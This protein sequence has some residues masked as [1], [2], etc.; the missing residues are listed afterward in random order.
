MKRLAAYGI[1]EAS[2]MPGLITNAFDLPIFSKQ[3]EI[4]KLPDNRD[5]RQMIFCN[6]E[7]DPLNSL[8][9]KIVGP[10]IQE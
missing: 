10:K 6:I 4:S 5:K 8:M 1:K 2:I 9:I 3:F 7:N